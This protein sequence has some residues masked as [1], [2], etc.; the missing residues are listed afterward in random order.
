MAQPVPRVDDGGAEDLKLGGCRLQCKPDHGPVGGDDVECSGKDP[1]HG[2]CAP[3]G[4]NSSVEELQS[5][6]DGAIDTQLGRALY[7]NIALT[8][9]ELRSIRPRSALDDGGHKAIVGT[10][11]CDVALPLAIQR[12]TIVTEDNEVFTEDWGIVDAVICRY[13]L[14]CAPTLHTNHAVSASK[15]NPFA[16]RVSDHVGEIHILSAAS[17]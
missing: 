11:R 1:G 14:H 4:Q 7:V 15:V 3:T 2:V 10:G 12:T 17:G 5:R 13:C 8:V 16:P 9:C 6:S